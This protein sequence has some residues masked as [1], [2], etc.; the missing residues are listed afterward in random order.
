MPCWANTRSLTSLSTG[1]LAGWRFSNLASKTAAAHS[2]RWRSRRSLKS[3]RRKRTRSP[4]F[5]KEKRSQKH[6][7]VAPRRSQQP[8]RR[9]RR[10]PT[11][12]SDLALAWRPSVTRFLSWSVSSFGLPSLCRQWSTATT[13]QMA[14]AAFTYFR[15]TK[16]VLLET[17][18]TRKWSVRLCRSALTTYM[19]IANTALLV[20]SWISACRIKMIKILLINAP[21]TNLTDLASQTHK[22][23]WMQSIL[24]LEAQIHQ[25]L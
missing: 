1:H 15:L 10:R 12:W 23:F 20:K 18:D 5:R 17:S 8:L 4:Y 14:T 7:R 2:A 11:R 22:P 21:L 6:L 25:L 3:A 24:W 19:L 13:R 9:R 16:A